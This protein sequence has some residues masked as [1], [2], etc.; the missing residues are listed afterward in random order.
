MDRNLWAEAR[1]IAAR[2]DP[3]AADDL[4]QE[5]VVTALERGATVARTGAWLER[6]GRNAAI[7]RWRVERRREELAA[8]I[9]TPAVPVDP[10]TALLARERRG[11]VRRAL[12]ALPRPQRRAALAR[13]HAELPFDDIAARLGTPPVTARTRVHRA[14]AALRVRLG[15]LRALFVLPGAQATALGLT[16]LAVEAPGIGPAPLASVDPLV[17]PAAPA[18]H[19]ART[20]VIAAERVPAVEAPPARAPRPLPTQATPVD[21]I[22][23]PQLFVFGNETIEGNN[24]G[25]EEEIVRIVLPVEQP[26]LIELRRHFVAEVAKTMEDSVELRRRSSPGP[27]GCRAGGRGT[28]RCTSRRRAATSSGVPAAITSPPRAPPSGPR[29]MT[30]SAVLMTSR[31]CSMTSTVLPAST[32]RAST[33]SSLRTSSK[34]RPVVGSSSR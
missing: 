3:Q 31:L 25:P 26:S 34:C 2:R 7:D 18:R 32:S 11:L 6:V 19:F 15:S 27:G 20:R 21:A 10:E 17:P 29:S 13:F 8:E 22:P 16:L 9:P 12:A 33:A 14:L 24:S 5:L 1:A 28:G 30:Q 4:A 23:S